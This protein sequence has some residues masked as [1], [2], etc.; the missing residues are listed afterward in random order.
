MLQLQIAKCH[1]IGGRARN[2]YGR[3]LVAKDAGDVFRL[4]PENDVRDVAR[5]ARRLL[6][7][8]R[9][10]ASMTQ[11]IDYLNELVSAPGRRGISMATEALSIDVDPDEITTVVP[12]YVAS[13]LRLIVAGGL[14]GAP[15]PV[16]PRWPEGCSR[17]QKNLLGSPA[18]PA[19]QP[20]SPRPLSR[21]ACGAG[22][23]L[24]PVLAVA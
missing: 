10:A 17:G 13:L 16:G 12:A 9:S 5:R 2:D 7:D 14:H 11:G 21:R 3:R 23:G 24:A 8:P 4:L 22:T 1:K 15:A 6:A 19:G 20:R 18:S